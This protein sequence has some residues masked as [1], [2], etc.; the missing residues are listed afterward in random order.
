MPFRASQGKGLPGIRLPQERRYG[1]LA[2]GPNHIASSDLRDRRV[3]C[4]MSVTSKQRNSCK[5]KKKKGFVSSCVW[6]DLLKNSSN[7][8]LVP[9][10][11]RFRSP[12]FSSSETLTVSKI[13]FVGPKLVVQYDKVSPELKV[14]DFRQLTTLVHVAWAFSP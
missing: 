1:Y 8:R 7:S 12:G 6:R 4:P 14:T 3:K 9:I 2:G 5:P 13:S 10:A 11:I